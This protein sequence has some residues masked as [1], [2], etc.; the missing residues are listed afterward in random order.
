MEQNELTALRELKAHPGWALFLEELKKLDDRFDR[1][2]LQMGQNH[3]L[4]RGY[5]IMLREIYEDSNILT[6][7]I[8][9]LVKEPVDKIDSGPRYSFL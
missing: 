6:Q 1:E 9:N 4:I 7:M 5:R 2:W 8:N 3:E